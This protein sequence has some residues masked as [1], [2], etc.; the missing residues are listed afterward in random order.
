ML[1]G[2]ARVFISTDIRE[3]D[4]YDE[5]IFFLCKRYCDRENPYRLFTGWQDIW[6]T[7]AIK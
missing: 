1:K 7:Q 4:T 5:E 6:L 2:P 3:A